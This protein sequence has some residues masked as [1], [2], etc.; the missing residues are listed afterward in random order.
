M[1]FGYKRKITTLLSLVTKNQFFVLIFFFIGLVMTTASTLYFAQTTNN[2]AG[3]AANVILGTSTIGGTTDTG[4]GNSITCNRYAATTSGTINAMSAYVAAIDATKKQYS[5]AVYADN[6]NN[7]NT[8][9]ISA[10]GT[11][12]ANS[13]NTLPLSTPVVAGSYYWL[14]YNANAT[15]GSYDNMKYAAGSTPAIYK[16]QP[17][18][19][20]PTSFGTVGGRWTDNYSIYATVIVDT[21]TTPT[22]TLLPTNT[23]T[24]TAI[25]PTTTPTIA[26]T[27]TP[28]PSITP[29]NI[30]SRSVPAFASTGTAS[31]ANDADYKTTWRS[32]AS[33]AWLTYNLSSVPAA[34]RGQ[35]A[36]VWYNEA[37]EAYD[38]ALASESLVRIPKNYTIQTN[39]AATGTS[40]PTTGWVTKVTISNNKYHSREHVF[41]MTGANWVR[42]NVTA[43]AGGSN[44]DINM[45][46]YDAATG[47]T[48]AWIIYGSSTPAMSMGHNTLGSITL[49]FSQMINQAKPNYFPIQENGSIS[50]LDTNDGVQYIN[51]WLPLFPG[52]YVGIA[53]GANDAD[54]CMNPTTFYNNY[55]TMVQAVIN[56][57]KVPVVPIF[58]WSKLSTVQSCGPALVDK[59]NQLYVA[60]PQVVKGPDFWRYFQSHPEL[61]SSDNQH[62]TN[63][64]AGQYRKLW[65][66][67]ALTNVYK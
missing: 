2:Q 36:L 34:K 39:N 38:P 51:T 59:I 61:I 55:V 8:L 26:V 17:F 28:A 66:E 9:L 13:W 12:T 31:R 60:Y 41:D 48:D 46:I 52:K 14:C 53:L 15:S 22:P 11:L 57:G 20:W 29:M 3:A 54:E 6:A 56:A 30:I 64:G 65:A 45:D 40:A 1:F 16:D 4:D 50:G 67:A 27:E 32:T 58:N 24:P 44:A 5:L 63:E 10:T 42:I 21:D 19:T 49:T 47:V 23:P 37:T 43:I 62:P 18:G 35:V 33:S 25:L 7:P